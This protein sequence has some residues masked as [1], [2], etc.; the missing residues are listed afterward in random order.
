[1][2]AMVFNQVNIVYIL[3]LLCLMHRRFQSL[4]T[5]YI[6]VVHNYKASQY[7]WESALNIVVFIQQTTSIEQ[8]ITTKYYN[9]TD[10]TVQEQHTAFKF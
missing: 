10:Y 5:E 7:A 3:H 1:M 4:K 8:Y 9:L 2:N 6:S